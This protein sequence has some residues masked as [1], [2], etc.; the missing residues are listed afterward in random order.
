MLGLP[1]YV[2]ISAKPLS[3]RPT[4]GSPPSGSIY[5]L[6]ESAPAGIRFDGLVRYRY[7]RLGV[8]SPTSEAAFTDT[9]WFD[10]EARSTL[11][12]R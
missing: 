1:Q 6:T 9:N 7:E 8:Y 4:I 2:R 5:A 11:S 3:G 10:H 12:S